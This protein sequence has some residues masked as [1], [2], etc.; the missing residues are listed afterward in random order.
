MNENF[1]WELRHGF[2][3]W[4]GY[5]QLAM[6]YGSIYISG[7]WGTGKDDC[8]TLGRLILDCKYSWPN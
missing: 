6:N 1:I 3:G 5:V 7:P 4:N 2:M 8:L